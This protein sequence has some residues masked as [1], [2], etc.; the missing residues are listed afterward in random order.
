MDAVRFMTGH[1]SLANKIADTAG[2]ER[3]GWLEI[4][5]FEEY[6]TAVLV[7]KRALAWGSGKCVTEKSINH[8]Y[9]AIMNAENQEVL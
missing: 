9:K 1:K 3:A 7:N 6:A 5:E 2:F 4:F 8:V